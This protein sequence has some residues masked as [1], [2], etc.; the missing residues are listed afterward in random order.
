ML[1]TASAQT[2][3]PPSEQAAFEVA[4]VRQNKSGTGGGQRRLPGGR[5]TATNMTLRALVRLAYGNA[6]IFR[7]EDQIV[8]GPGWIDS[9]RFD[10]EAKA[11]E[12]FAADPD[13]VTRQHLT[14]LR[15]LLEQ[16]F[17]LK[18]HMEK[19]EMPIY[20][21]VVARKDGKL[22]PD[23]QKSAL[24]CAPGAP[25]PNGAK[26]GVTSEG[27]TLVGRGVPIA[28]LVAFL[29]ISP[30]V[31]RLV[32]DETGLDGRFDA[33]LFFVR[34]FVL[35]PGGAVPNPDVDS[36][37]TIFTALQEQLGLKLES[38]R[39]PVDVLVIDAVQRLAEEK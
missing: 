35:G 33:R 34:P 31:G 12:E 19:R 3:A 17:S 10:I 2:P 15:T 22:G 6:S 38:R 21:L 26:C 29:T 39:A 23:L 11:A 14:M 36:G 5:F 25:P 16:R 30:A 9:D 7:P 4:S 32:Q 24:D 20:A 37:P 27:A 18:A 8:G 13:G 1:T 28:A